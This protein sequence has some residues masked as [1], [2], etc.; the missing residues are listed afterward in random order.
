MVLTY[1]GR[2]NIIVRNRQPKKSSEHVKCFGLFFLL[3]KAKKEGK[4]RIK[5]SNIQSMAEKL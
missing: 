5:F 1:H 2:C 4:L 3:L